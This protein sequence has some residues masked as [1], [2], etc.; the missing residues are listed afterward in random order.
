MTIQNLK[1]TRGDA[2]WLG[3]AGLAA[4]LVIVLAIMNWGSVA[5]ANRDYRNEQS[6]R[7][8]LLEFV[9]SLKD[10]ET[11]QRGFVI[12]GREEYL[13]PYNTAT[14]RIPL[15]LRELKQDLRRD[16]QM[17]K[18]LETCNRLAGLKLV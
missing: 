12:T 3:G 15:L 5:A 9:S 2:I 10:A 18:S 1:P 17:S 8:E 6:D 7:Q 14:S 4:L 16:A 13:D 11:G